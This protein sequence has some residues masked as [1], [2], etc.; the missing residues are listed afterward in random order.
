MS[1]ISGRRVVEHVRDQ[2]ADP[3]TGGPLLPCRN[4]RLMILDRRD[5]TTKVACEEDSRPTRAGSDIKYEG[6]PIEPHSLASQSHF[7]D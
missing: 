6:S 2:A 5:V 1:E 4:K 3:S 7:I